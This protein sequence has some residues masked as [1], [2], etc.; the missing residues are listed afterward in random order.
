MVDLLNA[1]SQ[2]IK[3][4][5]DLNGQDAYEAELV[6]MSPDDLV[7]LYEKIR[8]NWFANLVIIVLIDRYPKKWAQLAEAHCHGYELDRAFWPSTEQAR[9]III[10]GIVNKQ[11]CPNLY[12]WLLR[13]LFAGLL[14]EESAQTAAEFLKSLPQ[15]QQLIV[16]FYRLWA[17]EGS[18]DRIEVLKLIF[19]FGILDAN[20]LA[21]WKPVVDACTGTDQSSEFIHVMRMF[22]PSHVV[23]RYVV[24]K[25]LNSNDRGMVLDG[26]NQ[27]FL[28]E[29]PEELAKRYIDVAVKF[30]FNDYW[31]LEYSVPNKLI[32]YFLQSLASNGGFDNVETVAD[33]IYYDSYHYEIKEQSRLALGKALIELGKVR[34]ASDPANLGIVVEKAFNVWRDKPLRERMFKECILNDPELCASF[35]AK[36]DGMGCTSTLFSTFEDGV[37]HISDVEFAIVNQLLS[38]CLDWLEQNFSGLSDGTRT[39]SWPSLNTYLHLTEDGSLDDH[40]SEGIDS[41]IR[42]RFQALICDLIERE[43]LA[44]DDLAEILTGSYTS[45]PIISKEDNRHLVEKAISMIKKKGAVA[46]RYYWASLIKAGIVSIFDD[47]GVDPSMILDIEMEEDHVWGL[48]RQ[49]DYMM[50]LLRRSEDKPMKKQTYKAVI[51]RLFD[52]Q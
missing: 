27:G 23:Y 26:F 41:G 30:V 21:L 42:R 37:Q 1:S 52:V 50:N 38:G 5:I 44:A 31:R 17:I 14:F 51:Q 34:C 11:N 16:D 39:F 28:G 33:Q 40:E 25:L 24:Q 48:Q 6:R 13:K 15:R 43:R 47:F 12:G 2:Q 35:V 19:D 9:A 49:R 22:E 10:S 7:Q 8:L 29:M 36:T 4:F 46:Y 3:D 20:N 18:K 32:N 45:I